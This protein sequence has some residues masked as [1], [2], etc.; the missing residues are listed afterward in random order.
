VPRFT[1]LTHDQPVLHWDLLLELD[2]AGPLATWRILDDPG[3][4]VQW[5][6]EPLP[7]HRREY[8]DYEGPVSGDRG[9]V[10]GWDT[11]EYELEAGSAA[12]SGAGAAAVVTQQGGVMACQGSRWQGRIELIPGQPHWTLRRL[13]D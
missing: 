13:T 5:R 1:I 2:E 8:L 12:G 6:A 10:A 9:S 3:R 4:G 7:G 11:G